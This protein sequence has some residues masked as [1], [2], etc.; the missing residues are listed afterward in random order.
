MLA[1][2]GGT[3]LWYRSHEVKQAGV[4]HWSAQL[5]TQQLGAENLELPPRT[6]ALLAY[7]SAVAGRWRE[8]DGR[9]WTLNFFRW[10]PRS[11]QSII[12]ARL[13]RP[14]ICLP[15]AGFQQRS[16][17]EPVSFPVAGLSLPFRKY[18]YEREGKPIFVFF[19]QWEDGREQQAGMRA[20]KGADRIQSAWTGR[21]QLGQQT[22]ELI[23]T[24][25][26]TMAQAEAILRQRLPQL[27]QVERPQEP[28]A[29]AAAP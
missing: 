8:A 20:S 15:A 25:Y 19:C 24:G 2:L 18:E 3:E 27:I 29:R 17:S 12:H 6:V 14:E 4:F 5:P 13:H 11:V 23:A 16:E 9:S 7:D 10:K 28:S 1:V 26:D 22:L 21:R